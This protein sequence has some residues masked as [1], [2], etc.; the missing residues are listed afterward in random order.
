MNDTPDEFQEWRGGL[1]PPT[2]G[3]VEVIRRNGQRW[4]GD[5]IAERWTHF[6]NGIDVMAWRRAETVEEELA[7]LRRVVAERV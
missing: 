1:Y 7:R 6:G 2:G 5:A 4:T 3:R